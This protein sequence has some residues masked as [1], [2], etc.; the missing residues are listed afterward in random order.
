MHAFVL[1]QTTGAQEYTEKGLYST[2]SG[3]GKQTDISV[4]VAYR[5]I[6]DHSRMFTVCIADGL[7][8]ART[9]VE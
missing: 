7:L 6:A 5:I 1:L 3:I 4:D 8:P 2:A 9:G